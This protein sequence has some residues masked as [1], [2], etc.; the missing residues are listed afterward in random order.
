MG[1]KDFDEWWQSSDLRG[2]EPLHAAWMAW[3]AATERAAKVC[4]DAAAKLLDGKRI[5][6]VDRHVAD[7][8][9]TRAAAIRKGS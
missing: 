6:Q 9:Q 3:Q 4:E 1:R 2:R 8:L 7:V 5:N